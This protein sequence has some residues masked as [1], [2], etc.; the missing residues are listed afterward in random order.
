[1]DHSVQHNKYID[2]LTREATFQIE[3]TYDRLIVI[4]TFSNRRSGISKRVSILL[5]GLPFF[6]VS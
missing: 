1:M 4:D 3:Y 2:G 5:N 6:Y